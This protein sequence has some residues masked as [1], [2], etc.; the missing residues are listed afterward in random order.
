MAFMKRWVLLVAIVAVL[1]GPAWA[2]TIRLR[3][4]G[5]G[6]GQASFVPAR[7]LGGYFV[8]NRHPLPPGQD[9]EYVYVDN[10]DRFSQ[11]F[12]YGAIMGVEPDIVDEAFFRDKAVLG[13]IRSGLWDMKLDNVSGGAGGLEVSYSAKSVPAGFEA[14]TP[15]LV[16]I[17]KESGQLYRFVENGEAVHILTTDDVASVQRE[18]PGLR[19]AGGWTDFGEVDRESAG[20][21][22]RVMGDVAGVRYEPVAHSTQVVNGVNH[23]FVCVL[24]TVT[25]PVKKGVVVVSFHEGL[26]GRLGEPSIQQLIK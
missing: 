24:S 17:P 4:G 22:G 21:L 11:L 5:G 25:V 6:A 15:L 26:D 16:A 2:G 12:S 9:V 3:D 20:L 23:R 10:Y 19:V 18:N 7:E 8:S 13:V 14:V 1:A